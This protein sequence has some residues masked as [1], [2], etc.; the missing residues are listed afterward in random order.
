MPMMP[1]RQDPQSER[2]DNDNIDVDK[3]PRASANK[4]RGKGASTASEFQS[5]L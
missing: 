3:L 4:K 5:S 1:Q 2:V